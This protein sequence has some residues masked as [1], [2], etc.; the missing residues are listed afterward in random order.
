M[1]KNEKELRILHGMSDIAGQGSYSVLG[2]RYLGYDATMAVW[3]KNPFNYPV[4]ID[5]DLPKEKMRNPIYA[6]YAG[7]KIVVFSVKA[8]LKYDVFH[9]HFG[10]TLLPGRWDLPILKLLRKRVV[11][12]Y[13]GDDIRYCYYRKK[14]DFYPYDHLLPVNKKVLRANNRIRKYID[15]YI[16][17]DEELRK[18]IPNSN[19]FI[20][21]LRIDV[22]RFE[23]SYPESQVERVVIVHAPSN[24]EAKGTKYVI[25]SIETLKKKYN[26]E[27]IL[28]EG[29][30]QE[31]A[32]A[33]YKKADIIV[34]QLLAQTFGVF[35]LEAMAMGK[36]VIA[37][38]SEDIQ[39]SFPEDLPIQS[40]TIENITT[41]IEKLIRNGELRRELGF[42]GR[43]YVEN[44]HDY[45]KI[46]QVQ[47]DIYMNRINPM[48]TLDS[49]E[50]VKKKKV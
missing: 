35:S 12:E 20:T 24:P 25:S 32:L 10:H 8:I 3:R 5:L 27:F 49:Y 45:R 11:M 26:I 44:Y 48:G 47:M 16:T 13:H 50:Y 39:R 22:G 9:F 36:P 14:P 1:K 18:H 46:S 33:I 15:T 19:L 31:E 6:F 23:P 21:P 17:H 29:K 7:L 40:A 30:T 41:V 34:D 42:R 4:D 37:W 43:K 2:L 38:V 28:V